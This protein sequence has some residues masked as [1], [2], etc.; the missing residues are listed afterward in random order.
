MRAFNEQDVRAGFPPTFQTFAQARSTLELGLRLGKGWVATRGSRV[1]GAALAF[2]RSGVVSVGPVGVH[3]T[4]QGTGVGR[5]LMEHIHGD[6]AAADAFVLGQ[7]GANVV[8]FA[9]YRSLGY[10][11]VGAEV[12][13]TGRP[14][15]NTWPPGVR[16]AS[17]ADLDGVIALDRRLGG[18]DRG[19]DLRALAAMG[20]VLVSEEVDA[21]VVTVALGRTLAVGPGAAV[22]AKGLERVLAAALA[23]GRGGEA[24]VRAPSDS[25]GYDVAV[26]HGLRADRLGNVMVRG[27]RPERTGEVLYPI[28]PEVL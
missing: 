19:R 12:V 14:G 18:V 22:E 27:R 16:E 25:A 4:A 7:S 13:L 17:I 8:S 26:A 1:L 28:F 2:E 23:D 10:R 9:L 3:P 5:V 11:V 20:R 15:P 24:V 6:E 21:Y